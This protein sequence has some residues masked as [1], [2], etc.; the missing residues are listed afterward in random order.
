MAVDYLNAIAHVPSGS[1]ETT[2]D[3]TT[4]LTVPTGKVALIKGIH[5][6]N[7]TGSQININV[8]ISGSTGVYYLAKNSALPA[9][10]SFQPIDS[11][12]NLTAGQSLKVLNSNIDSGSDVTV[13]YLLVSSSV[14]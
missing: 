3:Y 14:S 5:H 9:Q 6:T 12:I 10:S 11:T 7:V 13:S 8:Q 4:L 1:E 2:G